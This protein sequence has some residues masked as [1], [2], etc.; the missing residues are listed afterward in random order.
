MKDTAVTVTSVKPPIQLVRV[1]EL[2]GISG[3][4]TLLMQL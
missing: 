1:G 2:L 3:R 4:L